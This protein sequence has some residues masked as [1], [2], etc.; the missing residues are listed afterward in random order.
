[1]RSKL[2]WI[3]TIIS[4][5]CWLLKSG[6]WTCRI[7][8]LRN[9]LKN[10][11]YRT[12]LPGSVHWFRDQENEPNI[13]REYTSKSVTNILLSSLW[14]SYRKPPQSTNLNSPLCQESC[15]SE[16]NNKTGFSVSGDIWYFYPLKMVISTF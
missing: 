16:T 1:M 13:L 15:N 11:S 4:W 14:E 5:F 8:N 6:F 10:S 2:G 3:V 9:S 12:V 7:A